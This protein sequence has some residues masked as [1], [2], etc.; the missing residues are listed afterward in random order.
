MAVTK[1][2]ASQKNAK[3][4]PKRSAAAKSAPLIGSGRGLDA[5]MAIQ[6]VAR[7][8]QNSET[9]RIDDIEP[10]PGQP[11]KT[12]DDATLAELAESVKNHGLLQP[13]IVTPAPAKSKKKYRI[14]AGERRYHA[15]VKAGLREVPVRVVRGDEGVLSEIALVENLQREDLN[16]LETAAAIKLL[17]EKHGLTQEKAA[18]RLGIA[19]TALANKLRLLQLPE[20]VRAAV[21]EGR[22]SEGHAKVLLSLKDNEKKLIK[23]A[24]DCIRLGWSVRTLTVKAGTSKT[25]NVLFQAPPIEGWKPKGIASLNR[26]LGFEIRAMAQGDENRLLLTGLTRDQV[27]RICDLLDRESDAL[28]AV[29]AQKEPTGAVS[30]APAKPAAKKTAKTAAKTAAKRSSKGKKSK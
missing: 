16:P 20:Q 28:A 29:P 23:L 2:S 30:T 5:L 7:P 13:I 9:V 6:N 27:Q 11:R 3:A 21:A 17:I 19:R 24:D 1:K 26:K 10:D 8:V 14:V 12:F 18:E 4:A 22:L 25:V 15:C